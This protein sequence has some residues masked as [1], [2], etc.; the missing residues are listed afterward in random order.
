MQG[1]QAPT[2]N[3]IAMVWRTKN[4]TQGQNA[5]SAMEQGG[6]RRQG[7][8]TPLTQGQAARPVN[9]QQQ[10]GGGDLGQRL[11]QKATADYQGGTVDLPIQ[12][13]DFQ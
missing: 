9:E 8:L 10:P 5:F 2:I 11:D 7:T 13:G 12:N 1:G 4:P 3:P 6:T